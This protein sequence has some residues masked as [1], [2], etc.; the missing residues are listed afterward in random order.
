MAV[1]TPEADSRFPILDSEARRERAS[2]LAQLTL[3]VTQITDDFAHVERIPRLSSSRLENDVEHSYMLA[4]LAPELAR[5]LGLDLDI[6]KI[7]EFALVH[8]LLELKVG[9]ANTFDLTPTEL[10]EKERR[11]LEAL[12]ELLGELPELTAASLKEYEAQ[13]TP[14]AVFVRMVDKLLPLAVDVVG[15]G[16]R[17]LREDFGVDTL[18]EL[19]DSHDKLHGRIAD[20]FGERFPD[21][22]AV[23][24]A[25]CEIVE[26]KYAASAHNDLS[27]EKTRGPNETEL[28]YLIDLDKLPID[29]DLNETKSK[30]LRQGYIAIGADGS[31]TRVRETNNG[32]KFE[33]TIKSPGMVSRPEQNIS[34]SQE[35]FEGLWRQTEGRRIFKTRH[36]IPYDE[37]TIELDIY[38]GKLAGLVTAEVE[39]D[40]RPTEAM[41][42]ATTFEQNPPEW[43]GENV[44]R[45]LKYKNHM[46]AQQP[47]RGTLE[48]GSKEA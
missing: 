30:Q 2:S 34:I 10:V 16:V 47:P 22:V 1:S 48:L 24:A 42:R 29:I 27:V 13:D 37:Y 35:M 44:S 8:D 12:E 41:I 39:F 28:K 19:V 31:E 7:R 46:L 15:D 14:E 18:E 6:A 40:G 36:Y 4:V 11:E 5:A 32:E 38:E 17:V 21:L 26:K 45:V 25:L 23:H 9:D 3:H 33:L 20:K 43:F